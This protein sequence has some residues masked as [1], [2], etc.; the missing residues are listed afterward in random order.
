VNRLPQFRHSLRRLKV[1]FCESLVSRV[2]IPSWLQYGHFKVFF[3][4]TGVRPHGRAIPREV[5][6]HTSSVRIA[7]RTLYVGGEYK[8]FKHLRED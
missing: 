8:T 6:L 5:H 4:R 1:F 7:K 2:L 3:P